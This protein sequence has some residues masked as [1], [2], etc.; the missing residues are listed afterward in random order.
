MTTSDA[1]RREFACSL[2]ESAGIRS[3]PLLD[4]F[5][6]V[7]R[8]DFVGAGPWLISGGN[9]YLSTPDANPEHL[10]ADVLVALDPARELNNGR[11]FRHARWIDALGVQPGDHVV[12]VGAG[13]GYYTA[14]LRELVGES[15]SV[16]AVERDRE[17]YRRLEEN[18]RSSP[19]VTV[20]SMLAVELFRDASR[21][22][23]N[24]ALTRPPRSWL[25]PLRDEAAMI[26]PLTEMGPD[27]C[28]GVFVV[29]RR[30]A[31]YEARLLQAV[32]MFP[33]SQ[34]RFPDDEPRIADA[35][36]GGGEELVRS[37]RLDAHPEEPGCW[38]H[39]ATGCLSQEPPATAR[40]GDTLG[41]ARV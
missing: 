2:S 5:S 23:I 6:A 39:L 24:C 19:N 26:L 31:G 35:F 41:K 16:T 37:L 8:E 28:G 29:R 21:V 12:H 9:P 38:L 1:K 22:Y 25:A 4:A 15:G 27:R 30:G 11:P 3:Q 18:F 14:I 10:Y 7:R 13:T 33:C 17:L 32:R 34:M 40:R 20:T 36:R